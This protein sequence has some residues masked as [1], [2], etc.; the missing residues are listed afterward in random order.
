ML[1]WTRGLSESC[2]PDHRRAG[3]SVRKAKIRSR[4]K[5]LGER[6]DRAPAVRGMAARTPRRIVPRFESCFGANMIRR[7]GDADRLLCCS[8]EQ[9]S[10]LKADLRG[11][12]KGRARGH[13]IIHTGQQ[14]CLGAAKGAEVGSAERQDSESQHDHRRSMLAHKPPNRLCTRTDQ[15]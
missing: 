14:L 1:V 15:P 6:K 10:E 9:W 2:L 8:H 11:W 7:S 5:V 4:I 3:T 12:N 13:V